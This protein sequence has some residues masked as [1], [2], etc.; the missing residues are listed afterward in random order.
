MENPANGIAEKKQFFSDQIILVKQSQEKYKQLTNRFGFFRVIYFV[1]TL[2]VSIY[3]INERD[4]SATAM[5]LLPFPFIFGWLV[6]RHSKHKRQL[7]VALNKI[8]YLEEELSRLDLSLSKMDG[9]NEFIDYAHPYTPDLDVFGRHSLFALINRSALNFGR[10]TLAQWFLSPASK[11][12]VHAR[13][14]AVDVLKNDNEWRLEWFAESRLKAS[15]EHPSQNKLFDWFEND[16]NAK[17]NQFLK[18]I[19]VIGIAQLIGFGVLAA[20]GILPWSFLGLGLFINV[21]LL[22]PVQ[23]KIIEVQRSTEKV[24]EILQQHRNLFK[25]AEEK[26]LENEYLQEISKVFKNPSAS[27]KIK[28]LSNLLSWLH[29]RHGMMYWIINP[30]ILSDYWIA[31]NSI[32]WKVSYGKYLRKWFVAIGE[33]EAIL[34][35][36]AYSFAHPNYV[37]AQIIDVQCTLD[38]RA[39]GHPLLPH[40]DRVNN[41]FLMDGKGSVTLITGANMSGKST[42]E[43]SLGVNLVLAQMG[44]VC[45]AESIQLSPLQIF[46]SMRTQDNLEENTSSFYAELKRLKQLVDLT[47]EA[48]QTSIFYLLDEILKGTNSED[49]NIGAESLIRQ[50]MKTNSMGLISTHDLSLAK[51]EKELENFQNYSFNSDVSGDQ[52]LFDYKL[53]EGPCHTFNAVPL[54]KK[55]GIEIV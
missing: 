50:L 2:V 30:F 54:M 19:P 34:S 7:N 1:I 48:R 28:T 14:E 39:I 5:I 8:K 43:R 40:Q 33:W 21:L 3:F 10:N 26:P 36:S 53:N 42:F 13:Q 20:M 31:N 44:A 35:L 16:E 47:Q 11:A 17:S 12:L 4:G 25:M 49:R 52:I 55:M 15:D 29:S 37:K 41:D 24:S 38:G 46:T 6:N 27:E 45:C 9:G 23:K 18:I 22:L 32:K 51:L